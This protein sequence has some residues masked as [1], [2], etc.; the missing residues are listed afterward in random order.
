MNNAPLTLSS[1]D[2]ERLEALLERPEYEHLPTAE[3][4]REELD[5]AE[6]VQP[7]AVP[8]GVVTMNSR[9]RFRDLERGTTLERTLTFPQRVEAV[10][11]G[12]SVLAPVGAALLGLSEGQEIDWPLPDGGHARLRIEQVVYQPEAAG[13]LH[14]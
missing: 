10:A 5:R 14:R 4:L 11:D 1:L 12:L 7:S 2:L 13:D 6:V 8:A 9:V 3:Q